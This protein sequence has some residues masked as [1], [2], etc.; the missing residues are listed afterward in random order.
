MAFQLYL[1]AEMEITAF[2]AGDEEGWVPPAG[3]FR[4]AGRETC[5]ESE[6]RVLPAFNRVAAV[7]AQELRQHS[8]PQSRP[9][10]R[11]RP[12]SHPS[13]ARKTCKN[14][15]RRISENLSQI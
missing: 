3:A 1:D 8:Q 12:L 7:N 10:P 2:T 11:P 9:R 13:L 5:L 14:L 6:L 15:R 4:R